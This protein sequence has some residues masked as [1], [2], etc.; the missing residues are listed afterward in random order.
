MIADRRSAA[1]LL[2]LLLA[3]LSAPVPAVDGPVPASGPDAA[4]GGASL[5][6]WT[7]APDPSTA[8]SERSRGRY[9]G[10]DYRELRLVSQT[11]RGEPWRHQLF[12]LRPDGVRPGTPGFLFISGGRWKPAYDDPPVPGELPRDAA[13][14]ARVAHR[15]QAPVA[16]L[17]QVPFQPMFDGLREDALIAYSFDQFLKTGDPDWPLLLPMVKAARVAMDAVQATTEAEWQQRVEQFVVAGASKRGWTAWLTAASQ[18]PRV[19]AI[20]PMVIDVL[21]M[22]RQMAHQRATWGKESAQI[23]DYT[24][25]DLTRRMLS[26]DGDGLLAIV[27]PWRYRQDL[28]LPK[29]IVL[30][31]NDA[32]WPVDSANI[33]LDGLPGESRLLYLPNNQHSVRDLRRLVAGF[34]ALHRAA[35]DGSALPRLEWQHGGSPGRATLRFRSDMAP[36]GARAW[37]ATAPTRDFRTARWVAKPA[38]R[39][40]DGWYQFS[41]PVPP[42]GYVALLG[43]AEF[44]RDTDRFYLSTGLR[45]FSPD[46][47]V[48]LTNGPAG[49][50]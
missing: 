14:F 2:L 7:A 50:P 15:L 32:Y 30:A 18:D 36:T 16:V 39:A 10:L 5:A 13:V 20:A 47:V 35:G 24:A 8:W 34:A 49:P 6:G 48:P 25:R 40:G 42:E 46:G 21:D 22:P 37:Y 29:L 44:G 43:E 38:R 23:E 9:R 17:G 11:W 31:T 3:A 1:A 19:V 45:V 4:R 12:V 28:G 27:D 41:V 33:Y 26:P